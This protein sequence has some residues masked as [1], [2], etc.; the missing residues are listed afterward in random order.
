MKFSSNINISGKKSKP[1]SATSEDVGK[2]KK[3]QEVHAVGLSCF[4]DTGAS[5][6][7]ISQNYV[8]KFRKDLRQNEII[9]ET[10]SGDYKTK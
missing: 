10:A 8:K 3:S 5:H 1:I 2:G 4:W 9:Y 7:V 6:Y